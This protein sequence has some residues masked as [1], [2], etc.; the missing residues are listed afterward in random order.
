MTS[1]SWL[2]GKVIRIA[3]ET[4]DTSRFWVQVPALEKFDFIP[5]QFVNLELSNNRKKRRDRIL[6]S[7]S[8]ASWPDG[9]NIFELIIVLEKNGAGTTVLFKGIKAGSEL[10][11]QGPY[12]AFRLDEPIDKDV[13]MICTGTGIAPF[14]S[15]L[16]YIKNHNIPHHNIYLIFGC[17]N[18]E[19]LLYHDEMKKLQEDLHGFQYIPTLSRDQW[20]GKTGYVHSVYETLCRERKPARFLLAGSKFMINE[21]KKIITDMGYDSKTMH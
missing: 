3:G 8:I 11:L 1:E 18:K 4:I 15:M 12:G 20:E 14:R 5:G 16:H 21:A 10:N 7:Y 6:R 2:K 19:A 13:F 17:R 9:T